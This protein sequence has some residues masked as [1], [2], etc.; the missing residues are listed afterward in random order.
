MHLA[1]LNLD[2]EVP[3]YSTYP[4]RQSPWSVLRRQFVLGDEALSQDLHGRR[5]GQGCRSR[6]QRHRG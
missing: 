6:C 1:R 4:L 5:F 3:N 2:D